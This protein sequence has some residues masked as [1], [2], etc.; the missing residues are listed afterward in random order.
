MAVTGKVRA[1]QG[2]FSQI[3]ALNRRV[4]Q[5]D[6]KARSVESMLEIV[7]GYATSLASKQDTLQADLDATLK[8]VICRNDQLKVTMKQFQKEKKKL[9]RTEDK[10]FDLGYTFAVLKAHYSGLDQKQILDQGIADPVEGP[11]LGE[12]KLVISSDPD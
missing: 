8:R 9:I 4:S 2:H 7:H 3:N 10:V 12:E 5:A 6:G 11:A 1:L